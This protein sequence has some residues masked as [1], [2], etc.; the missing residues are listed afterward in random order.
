MEFLF[1]VFTG[2]FLTWPTFII[3]CGL[4]IIFESYGEHTLAMFTGIVSAV[5][6][7]FFFHID[8]MSIIVYIV[9]YFAIGFGWCIWRYKRHASDVVDEFR[10]SSDYAREQA[11]ANLH[12]VR[13]LNVLTTWVLVWPFSMVE[14]VAGDLIK[15]IQTTITK[16]FKS[17]FNRIYDQAVGQLLPKDLSKEAETS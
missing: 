13:M 10:N 2:Y 4:G 15:L 3:L 1:G 9:G 5:V 11:A 12:P 7:Y 14:N 17:I 8:P 16:V 6:A